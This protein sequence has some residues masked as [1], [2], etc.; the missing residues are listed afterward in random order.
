V[1]DATSQGN[2]RAS[3]LLL[4]DPRVF[5]DP[6]PSPVGNPG[7]YLH[8][9]VNAPKI[10]RRRGWKR[11]DRD[12]TCVE[13]LYPRVFPGDRLWVRE[14]FQVESNFNMDGPKVYPPPF[15][16]GRPT[17]KVTAVRVQRLQEIPEADA[18]AEGVPVRRYEDGRGVETSADGFRALWDSINGKRASWDSN[19][20]VWVLEFRRVA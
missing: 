1:T 8:A 5:V 4:D 14:A 18:R 20:W 11:G 6:G 13:R 9:T 7:P 17:L 2:Y 19:P 3:E 15:S 10:E 12:D 16:D